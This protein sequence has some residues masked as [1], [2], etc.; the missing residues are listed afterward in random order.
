MRRM[1]RIVLAAALVGASA[2][3]ASAANGPTDYTW[4][5]VCVASSLSTCASVEVGYVASTG[6]VTMKIWNLGTG[7]SLN[8]ILTQ[9]GLMNNVNVVPLGSSVTGMTGFIN[10]PAPW[11]LYNNQQPSGGGRITLD[12]LAASGSNRNR[13]TS[14]SNNG[15]VNS[16]STLASSGKYWVSQCGGGTAVS[17]SFSASGL[18]GWDL[19]LSRLYYKVQNGPNGNSF[20]CLTGSTG[21]TACGGTT[22]PEPVTLALLATGLSGVALPTLRRRRRRSEPEA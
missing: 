14:T 10:G 20:E 15:I 3:G 13:Q 17:F 16:C 9:L 21:S 19:T 12:F 7:A 8:Q 1:H 22:T 11:S 18:A 5:D 2:T 6:V 4:N